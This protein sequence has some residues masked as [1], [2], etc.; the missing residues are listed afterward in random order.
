MTYY[1]IYE[2]IPTWFLPLRGYS[3]YNS[4]GQKTESFPCY[5]LAEKKEY[6]FLKYNI[7]I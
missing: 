6:L 4:Q 3:V 1:I 2:P 7:E 5:K